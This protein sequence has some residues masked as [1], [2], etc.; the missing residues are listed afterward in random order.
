MGRV[1]AAFKQFFDDD[2]NPLVNGWLRFLEPSTNNTDKNTFYDPIYQIPNANPLQLDAAGR[3]PDVYG[4]GN[5]RII[6]YTNDPEDE[7]SPG[8][9]IQ[10]FDPVT[11]QGEVTGGGGS[12]GFADWD[13]AEDYA[14][15]DLVTYNL[16][17]YRAL[18]PN[19][20]QNPA[21]N[22]DYWEQFDFLVWYNTTVTY[23]ADDLVYYS[24]NLYLS[25]QDLNQGNQPDVSPAWWRPVA[26]CYYAFKSISGATYSM[27]FS[28][29]DKIIGL[30]PSATEACTVTLLPGDA[31]TDQLRVAF[32]NCSGYDLIIHPPGSA[33]LWIDGGDITLDE[34][35]LLELIYCWDEDKWLP[36]ANAGPV[37]GGQ[38]IGTAGTPVNNLYLLNLHVTDVYVN[39]F[40]VPSDQY[41]YFGDS[42]EASIG[43]VSATPVLTLN[44]PAGASHDFLIDSVLAW[45]MATTGEFLPGAS[46]PNPNLGS[47]T[48]PVSQIY[49]DEIFLPNDG[50]AVFGDLS[51]MQIWHSGVQGNIYNGTGNLVYST[52]STAGHFFTTAGGT[53]EYNSLGQLDFSSTTGIVGNPQFL[54]I[55]YFNADIYLPFNNADIYLGASN[56]LR[57]VHTGTHGY[58]D[59]TIGNFY[60]RT[61]ATP[62]NALIISS[63]QDLSLGGHLT[64]PANHRIYFVNSSTADI[65]YSTGLYIGSVANTGVGIRTNNT[66]RWIF[67]PGGTLYP[68]ANL[69][70]DIGGSLNRVRDV[71]CNAV[72][73]TFLVAPTSLLVGINNS[74][75]TQAYTIT[76]I[77]VVDLG[78]G[79]YR[80]DITTTSNGRTFVWSQTGS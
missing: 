7:D 50:A 65:Y 80:L 11:A 77:S 40:H 22:P 36:L 31:T 69:A 75:T 48:A 6:S 43:Y 67:D 20:G 38:D 41:G 8:E 13:P 79:V 15:G 59:N 55:T 46:N 16:I 42:D 47:T 73:P 30:S 51:E 58:I 74:T 26:C 34:G 5:Y 29:R 32:Y 35:A 57:L 64:M 19:T 45:R 1:I 63:T 60:I 18:A 23:S 12:A 3:C 9:Q 37:L 52:V 33:S 76:N 24:G 14:L 21:T 2:G 44:V 71:Y 70:Y 17:Y 27:L 25:E 72:K 68:F 39:A 61:G 54:D 53:L 56:Q 49:T 66:V 62:T 78:G 28:D 10:V 4:T